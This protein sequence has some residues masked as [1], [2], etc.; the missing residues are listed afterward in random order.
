MRPIVHRSRRRSRQPKRRSHE[1]RGPSR[2]GS[3]TLQRG[4]VLVREVI[5]ARS[6]LPRRSAKRVGGSSP[7]V[8]RARGTAAP[9]HVAAG[10]RGGLS[11]DDSGGRVKPVLV[12]CTPRAPGRR[13]GE[14]RRRKREQARALQ[15]AAA[16][17][18]TGASGCSSRAAGA[19]E[20]LPCRMAGRRLA[21]ALFAA[22]RRGE[23][24]KRPIEAAPSA[25]RASTPKPLR[26]RSPPP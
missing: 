9:F 6:R 3:T 26:A 24:R 10:S 8:A 13:R 25:D 23:A 17:R 20:C 18:V 4:T 11:C 15:G 16:R 12:A 1:N 21:A 2:P 19:L 5:V 14:P 22:A 7:L